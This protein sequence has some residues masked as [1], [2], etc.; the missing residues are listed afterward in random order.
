ML[1][2]IYVNVLNKLN[3]FPEILHKKEHILMTRKVINSTKMLL[4][5]MISA[6]IN[7]TQGLEST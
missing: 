5:S 1:H 7:I 6:D 4:N 2:H 3:K